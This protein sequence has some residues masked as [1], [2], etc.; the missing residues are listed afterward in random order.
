M[1][2]TLILDDDQSFARIVELRLKTWNADLDVTFAESI[3]EAKEILESAE[4]EF[5]LAILD[6]HLP[7]GLGFELIEHPGLQNT[8]VLS[9]SSDD[10]PD[11][12]VQNVKAGAGY[13]L[14]KTE[15]A[16]SI[17]T[18]LVDAVIQRKALQLQAHELDLER[19][20]VDT[21]KKLLSTLKHEI[22]NP[23]GAV[24]GATYLLKSI[25]EIDP[26]HEE[27]IELLERSSQRINH[28]LTQL[29]DT[30]ELEEV[31]KGDEELYHVPGDEPWQ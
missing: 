4:E 8:A 22:N 25:N 21:I 27:T 9:V 3:T 18:S 24:F 31:T 29:A 16:T 5:E 19:T 7:D 1:I 6:Q 20:K 12:P 17:F 2:K 26:K 23:L 28:V 13:F 30:A 15:V 10:N 14:K 11:L